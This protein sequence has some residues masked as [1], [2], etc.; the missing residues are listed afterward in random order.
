MFD[1]LLKDAK[2]QKKLPN[3]KLRSA[4]EAF[5]WTQ[6]NKVESSEEERAT[7]KQWL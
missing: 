4:R 7:V 2:A 1:L 5:V 6:E 3:S